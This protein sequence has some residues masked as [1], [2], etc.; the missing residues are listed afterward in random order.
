MAATSATSS[1]AATSATITA[2]AGKD[3]SRDNR[4]AIARAAD[5][6][7]FRSSVSLQ[8]HTVVY[9]RKEFTYRLYDHGPRTVKCPIV[10]LPPVSGTGD[11]WFRQLMPLA[12]QGFRCIALEYSPV[13]TVEE[14]CET[15]ARLL[16][17]LDVTGV[18]SR[19]LLL[20]PAQL[21]AVVPPRG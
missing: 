11:V 12:A 9:L 16:Q 5:Y 21:H 13:D 3:G 19:D 2:A 14:F 1:A 4:S 6:V 20:L 18:S 10:F 8:R 7:S 15:F 17:A